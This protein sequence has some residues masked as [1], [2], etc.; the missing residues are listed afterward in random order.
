MSGTAIR[1]VDRIRDQA[2]FSGVPGNGAGLRYDVTGA[3]FHP[4]LTP[5]GPTYY[6]NPATGDDDAPGTGAAVAWKTW[7]RVL[8]AIAAGVAGAW[9]GPAGVTANLAT[10]P[11]TADRLA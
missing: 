5:P 4:D 6:V 3:K 1:V 11:N 10:I 7:G 2:D 9:I 8:K